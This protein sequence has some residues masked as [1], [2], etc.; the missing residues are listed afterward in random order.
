MPSARGIRAG[1]A[2]VEITAH[3]LALR[4]GLD[5][6]SARIRAFAAGVHAAG[7]AFIKW[8]GLVTVALVGAA[9]AFGKMGDTIA[10]MSKRTGV[11][12]ETLSEL[13]FA[14]GRSGTSMENIEKAIRTMQRSI[15]DLNLGLS[16]SVDAF[17]AMGLS[18]K[19]VMGLS[20]SEQFDTITEALAGIEDPSTRAA[21]AMKVFGR[22]GTS[23]IPML[24]DMK[25]LREEARRLGL[26]MSA[27]D[28]KAAEDF[29]DAMGDLWA[30]VKRGVFHIG[31]GLAPILTDLGN[32][33][34]EIMAKINA[35][36][37]A[38]RGLV[39]A[40][41]KAAAVTMALGVA[42]VVLAKLMTVAALVM[43]AAAV[44]I[45]ILTTAISVAISVIT[46]LASPIGVVVAALAGLAA[47]AIYASG[48]VGKATS[49]M[50]DRWGELK[51]TALKAFGG[52]RDAM[53]AGDI[54]LAAKIM[55]AGL[56]IAW[57]EGTQPLY[58]EWKDLWNGIKDVFT[59]VWKTI[60]NIFSAASAGFT[61][62]WQNIVDFVA[63]GIVKLW[64]TIQKIV[65][66]QKMITGRQSLSELKDNVKAIDEASKA[67]LAGMKSSHKQRIDLINKQMNEDIAAN[68]EWARQALIAGERNNTADIAARKDHL[69][70]LKDQL[71]ELV[72][73]A[74]DERAAME[75]AAA[76]VPTPEMPEP[77]P[78][79]GSGVGEQLKS[80]V[81]G[82][83]SGAAAGRIGPGMVMTKI[84]DS[85][86]ATAKNTASINQK[87]D[88]NGNSFG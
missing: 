7:M 55:W 32:K 11:A 59:N 8:G 29:T 60:M 36:I 41:L 52:I 13:E 84:A 83:F 71:D 56:Q 58:E 10:K 82:T 88:E 35:W 53:M 3:D 18:L 47:Y 38:N 61:H 17:D 67:T 37:G 42:F 64:A 66:G 14:A 54:E 22:A 51:D 49:Y 19:D 27:E 30:S 15:F 33:I 57:M 75:D 76:G 1:A 68:D 85:V 62:I 26:V 87:M 39:E 69:A 70:D 25:A 74:A 48:A 43:K 21:V 50:Q 79:P 65:E 2:F 81:F 86:D 40:I 16:T 77:P 5:R 45:G 23:L 28:A 9:V 46:F 12:V 6:A 34:A 78:P 73:Q 63:A 4:K 72:Q 24:G 80:S 20:P 31:A 44:A